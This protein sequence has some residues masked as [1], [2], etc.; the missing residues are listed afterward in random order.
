MAKRK[1]QRIRKQ[2][3][4]QKLLLPLSADMAGSVP[5]LVGGLALP[6]HSRIVRS[7]SN[8]LSYRYIFTSQHPPTYGGYSVLSMERPT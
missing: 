4:V 3:G 7:H 5:F 6:I 8:S 1:K 2:H